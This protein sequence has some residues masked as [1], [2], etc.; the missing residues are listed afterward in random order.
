MRSTTAKRLATCSEVSKPMPVVT[1]HLIGS[2]TPVLAPTSLLDV[3]GGL[4]AQLQQM[5]VD[6]KDI[7]SRIFSQIDAL[8]LKVS[9]PD[10]SK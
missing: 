3:V 10:S 6:V 8:A 4:T 2:P 9:L 5:I 7:H 1:F